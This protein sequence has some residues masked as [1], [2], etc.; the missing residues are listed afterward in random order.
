MKKQAN[1]D[2]R[3]ANLHKKNK[4]IWMKN[5]Q[6]WMIKTSK[7]AHKKKSIWTKKQVNLDESVL[8]I[9]Y[10]LIVVGTVMN[11]HQPY[12]TLH[13]TFSLKFQPIKRK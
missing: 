8:Y 7:S 2:E 5:R 9:V 12:L 6:I 13:Q 3:Q 10:L 1:Q 11:R 4:Q